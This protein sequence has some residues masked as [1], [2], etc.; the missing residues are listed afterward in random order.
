MCTKLFI[1]AMV[2]LAIVVRAPRGLGTRAG[3]CADYF[4]FVVNRRLELELEGEG[5]VVRRPRSLGCRYLVT[6]ESLLWG[7]LVGVRRDLRR[8]R[9]GRE[10]ER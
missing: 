6:G 5:Q 7:Y 1:M 3:A 8:E 9:G 2:T 10:R 4:C